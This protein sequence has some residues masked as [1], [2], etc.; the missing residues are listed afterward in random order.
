[1]PILLTSPFRNAWNTVSGFV[2]S[3]GNALG[4]IVGRSIDMD[5]NIGYD[6]S[7]L[8]EAK[9]GIMALNEQVNSIPS[10]NVSQYDLKGRYYTPNTQ[11]SRSFVDTINQKQIQSNSNSI[12]S[13]LLNKL[14]S[15]NDVAQ[16]SITLNIENFNNNRDI[17][18][19][20]LVEEI[21][22]YLKQRTI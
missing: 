17:D 2:S 13:N 5:M 12:S 20:E 15:Q 10:T 11:M 21:N 18:I 14:L 9:N 22:F 8:Q 1:M 7:Q 6:D 4:S 19:R 3:I 16:R